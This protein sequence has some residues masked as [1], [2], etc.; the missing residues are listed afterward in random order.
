MDGT[1]GHHP[2][3]LTQEQKTKYHTF[4]LTGGSKMMRTYGHM[5]RGKHTLG[6]LEAGGGRRRRIRKNSN[7]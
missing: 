3:K 2:N 1:G 7:S 4:S 5:V 6:L